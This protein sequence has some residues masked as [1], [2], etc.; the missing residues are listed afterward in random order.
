MARDNVRIN[1]TWT[2]LMDLAVLWG[3]NGGNGGNTEGTD[4]NVDLIIHCS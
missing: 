1:T 4:Y 3:G 2:N